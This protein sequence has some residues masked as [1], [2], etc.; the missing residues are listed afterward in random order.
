MGE[1][2]RV[3]FVPA[4]VDDEMPASVCRRAHGWNVEKSDESAMY[5]F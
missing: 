3:L 4:S 2:S 1:C 5:L